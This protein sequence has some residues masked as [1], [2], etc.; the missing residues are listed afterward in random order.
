MTRRMT[1]RPFDDSP[2]LSKTHRMTQPTDRGA[3]LRALYAA[4]G[5]VRTIFS[6]KVN[7]YVASRPDYP[8]ALFESLRE[9]AALQAGSVVA[10]VGAGTGLLTH[11]LLQ[12][13]CSVGAVEPNPAMRAA[14][15]HWLGDMPGYRSA[16]G[17]AE[18]LPLADRSV[19][20]ITAAQAFHWFEVDA[21]RTECL[22]VL[23]PHGQVALIWN[24]RRRNDPL[25]EALDGVFNQ[26][27]GTKRTALVVHEDRAEVPRFFGSTTARAFAWPHE[28]HLSAAALASL[29]FSR[30]YMPERDS[31]TGQAVE[32]ALRGVF[33]RFAVDRKVA[34]R[35]TTVAMVGRPG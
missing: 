29:V 7:D 25:H 4:Q 32:D 30:S 8:A 23:R 16:E 13:G 27:G 21:A 35:Y 5:G 17:S 31:A 10:D 9:H 20:L 24:D 28:H 18:H 12:R 19:D 1:R 26:F 11:G 6:A 14:A 33:A 22:R 3:E 2:D 15:D 34:V